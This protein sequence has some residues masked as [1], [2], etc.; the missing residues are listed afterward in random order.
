MS[1]RGLGQHLF[2]HATVDISQAE[3]A[4]LKPIGQAG[5]V[6]SEQVQQRRIEIVDMDGIPRDV[7]SQFVRLTVRVPT[8]YTTAGKPCCKAAVMVIAAIVATL[9]HRSA[10]KFAP[11]DD[12]R[13]VQQPALFKVPQQS[14]GSLVGRPAII[15]DAFRQITV[16]IP[17]FV[18]QLNKPHSTFQHPPRQ[19]AIPRV[20]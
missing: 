10:S 15:L 6:Q 12:Q 11:P 3:I 16:L 5:V 4:S 20:T 8:P 19:Q 1:L 13:V 7:E 14:R 2:D 17:D 18:K 9:H